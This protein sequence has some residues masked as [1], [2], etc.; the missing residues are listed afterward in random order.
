MEAFSLME[1]RT[2]LQML[3]TSAAGAKSQAP[4]EQA[5]CSLLRQWHIF[6]ALAQ[7]V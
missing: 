1:I 4:T 5:I 2:H 6:G 7:L 3:Q